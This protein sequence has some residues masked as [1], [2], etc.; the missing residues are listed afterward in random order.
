[1]SFTGREEEKHLKL[2]DE[3]HPD[4]IGLSLT[5][6]FSLGNLI[7]IVEMVRAASPVLPILVGGAGLTPGR[8]RKDHPLFI[9]RIYS[10]PA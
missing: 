3:K 6:F 10:F 7:R 9:R 1:M 4:L 8:N 2:I 5:I